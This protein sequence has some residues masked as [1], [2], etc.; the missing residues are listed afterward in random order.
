MGGG[1]M[2]WGWEELSVEVITPIA[3]RER[4]GVAAGKRCRQA[5][6]A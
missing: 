2:T 6:A 4:W 3:R 1:S 5:L